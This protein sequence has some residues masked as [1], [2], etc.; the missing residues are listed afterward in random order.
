M[1]LG[2][3][4]CKIYPIETAD[5]PAPAKRPEFGVLNKAKIKSVYGIDISHWHSSLERMIDSLNQTETAK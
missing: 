1:K 4:D 5:Y 3:L 2:G